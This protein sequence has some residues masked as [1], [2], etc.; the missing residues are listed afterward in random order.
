MF[1][2]RDWTKGYGVVVLIFKY[3]FHPHVS[4]EIFWMFAHI[5]CCNIWPNEMGVA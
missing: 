5:V 3:N 2:E 4:L 1:G